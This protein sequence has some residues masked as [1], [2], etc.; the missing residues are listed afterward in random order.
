MTAYCGLAIDKKVAIVLVLCDLQLYTIMYS[1]VTSFWRVG[2]GGVGRNIAP[3]GGNTDV[4]HISKAYVIEDIATL[5]KFVY[6]YD[7]I[8]PYSRGIQLL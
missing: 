4:Y 2:E 8:P 7:I 3:Y 5:Y 1:L 6:I